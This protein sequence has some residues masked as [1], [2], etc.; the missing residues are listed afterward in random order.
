MGDSVFGRVSVAVVTPFVDPAIDPCQPIDKDSLE[1][2]ISHVACGLA[3]VRKQYKL[4]G[5]I[6]V[7]GSTGEQHTMSLEERCFAYH[8]AVAASKSLEVP[9]IA[10]VAYTTISG[11]L[12]L[13]DAALQ[14]GCKGI[15]L[16]LPPYC[17]MCDEEIYDY[18]SAVKARV[19]KSFPLLLYNN[20]M[21]NGYGPSHDLLVE[22][23]RSG[24][25]WG[26][27]HAVAPEEF[28]KQANALLALEPSI[29]LYTGSDKL[30]GQILDFASLDEQTAATDPVPRFYGLTSIVGNLFPEEVGLMV[31]K[32]SQCEPVAASGKTVSSSES[33]NSNSSESSSTTGDARQDGK[34]LHEHLLP[35][36]DAV[37]LGCTLPV[38]LKYALRHKG[39]SGGHTRRPVGHL[40]EKKA[41]EIDAVLAT[42]SF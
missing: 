26:V 38:G 7:S 40:S 41:A 16:G 18:V 30:A 28:M 37:L 42:V 27:K 6:I 1:A 11:V 36:I 31:A 5:G 13:T 15:M 24:T 21:R 19:P 17:R 10:G 20:V 39:L 3:K 8:I 12:Q 29:R 35:V 2:I 33:S 32:I 14:A 25:I 23:S 34:L 4:V 9:I 22:L